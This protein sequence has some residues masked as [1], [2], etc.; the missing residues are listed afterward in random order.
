[1]K[2]QT[3]AI[4]CFIDDFFHT[5]GRKD[6]VHCKIS[7]AEILTTALMAARYFYDNLHSACANMQEHHGV[8]MIDKSGFTRRLHGLQQQLPALFTALGQSL[9]Q[10]NT[11]CRYLI[12]SF[13]VAVCDNIR[14]CR[15]HLVRGEAY[16]GKNV[17]K[18]RY[19]YGLGEG[20]RQIPASKPGGYPSPKESSFSISNAKAACC[21][22]S[23]NCM[24]SFALTSSFTLA[25]GVAMVICLKLGP[26]AFYLPFGK[27]YAFPVQILDILVQACIL[28]KPILPPMLDDSRSIDDQ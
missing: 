22:R 7:D 27:S 15:S 1:M 11:G 6:D 13:P 10:L 18:R 4:Y 21:K 24:I 2:E 26:L 14:I 8:R 5:I 17:S 20:E 19:F 9:K 16:R 28:I 3:I 12:D 23:F 25:D